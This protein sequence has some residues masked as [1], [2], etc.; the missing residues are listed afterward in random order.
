MASLLIRS[1]HPLSATSFIFVL[2][3]FPCFSL[4][5]PASAETETAAFQPSSL[6]LYYG[7]DSKV[8]ERLATGLQPGAVVIVDLR[9]IT[10]TA[11]N[12]LLER[13]RP[14]GSKLISYVSIGELHREEAS[15]FQGFADGY[16][17][18]AGGDPES[19][20]DMNLGVNPR[21]NTFRVDVKFP[22]W[23]SFV[24]NRVEKIYSTG[25]DGVLLDNVDT[26]D[27]YL[28]HETWSSERAAESVSAMISLI[29][30]IKAMDPSKYVI[31]NRGLNLISR[32]IYVQHKHERPQRVA[33]LFLSGPEQN[34]PD[35]V[36]WE[37][38]FASDD[39]WTRQK[40]RELQ[41]IQQSERTDVFAL[42]YQETQPSPYW[43]FRHCYDAGFIGAWSAST[44]RLGELPALGEDAIEE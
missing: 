5:R 29:R 24:R 2:T 30:G 13:T 12:W 19:L 8:L 3:F 23:Q 15:Y 32:V 38:A 25:V 37:D 34:N 41:T 22:I 20:D 9:S 44:E 4:Q 31:M 35:A 28:S 1:F 18:G 16:W 39:Q 7:G 26:V 6:S 14:A 43:F 42:G 36:L 33:G 21:F 10:P 17:K 40:S 27:T 11:L